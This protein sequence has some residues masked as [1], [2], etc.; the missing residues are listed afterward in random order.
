[1]T[2]PVFSPIPEQAILSTLSKH[3][4]ASLSGA[5]SITVI[6]SFSKATK[7]AISLNYSEGADENCSDT[8]PLKS[9]G[10]YTKPIQGMKPSVKISGERKRKAGFYETISRQYWELKRKLDR[11]DVIPWARFNS[12]GSIPNRKLSGV[13]TMA[14]RALLKLLALHNI[15]V[16]FPV[17]TETKRRELARATEGL[18]TVRVSSHGDLSLD[19]AISTVAGNMSMS[20]AE[21][22]EEAHKIRKSYKGTA[23]VCP[24]ITATFK[25]TKDIKCGDCTACANPKIKLIIYPMH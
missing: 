24:A 15:P 3:A 12:F 22:L 23:A 8:C 25:R 17:E 2:M 10:C 9:N 13:E 14:L 4:Y 16:H 1:M 20:R 21:R 11:G 18:A 6:G 19:G 7:G 5:S